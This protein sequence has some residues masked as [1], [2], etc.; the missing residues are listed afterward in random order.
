MRGSRNSFRDFPESID[1]VANG[2]I[3][4]LALVTRTISFEEAPATIVEIAAHPEKFMKVVA[5][6]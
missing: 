1:L 2:K 5:L 4:V 3:D 6:L